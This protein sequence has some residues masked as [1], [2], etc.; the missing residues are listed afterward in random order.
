MYQGVVA[1]KPESYINLQKINKNRFS[2]M[3]VHLTPVSR[4]DNFTH[5]SRR[6]RIPFHLL[7]QKK[8]LS[9]PFFSRQDVNVS[10]LW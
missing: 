9:D 1:R 6:L 8:T 2:I 4:V 5:Y 10:Y 3:F 7:Q